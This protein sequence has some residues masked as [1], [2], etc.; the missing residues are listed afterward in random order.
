VPALAVAQR[1]AHL[2]PAPCRSLAAAH[3]KYLTPT[4]VR[5]VL[6]RVWDLNE[7]ILAYIYPTGEPG[8]GPRLLAGAPNCVEGGDALLEAARAQPTKAAL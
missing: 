2:C 3:P 1:A 5:E 6:R 8:R 7:P 4:E